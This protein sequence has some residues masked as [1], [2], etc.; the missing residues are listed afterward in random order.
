MQPS[1]QD[2]AYLWDRLDAAKAVREFV[3]SLR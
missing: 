3:L 2:A 1:K